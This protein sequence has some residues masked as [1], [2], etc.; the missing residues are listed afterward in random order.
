MTFAENVIS[1]FNQLQTPD[2]PDRIGVMNPY[3]T[4]EVSEIVQQFYTKYYGDNNPRRLIFGINPG[5]FGS[6]ITG[7]SFTD[8]IRLEDVCGIPNSFHKRQ[9]TSSVFVYNFIEK[10]GGPELFY[11]DYFITATFPLG[12]LSEG[13]NINYYDDKALQ[14]SVLELIILYMKE[15]LSW[16][17]KTDVAYCLGKGKNLKFLQKL[18]KEHQFFGEI[19]PLPHPRWVMQYR[20]KMRDEFAMDIAQELQ[21]F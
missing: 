8:P 14:E 16:N 17:V 9:E 2:V 13:K 1:F 19:K 10:Y 15:Q 7:I 5:R 3:Q 20:Y 4:K 6:G 21:V 12:F 11:R 18:N